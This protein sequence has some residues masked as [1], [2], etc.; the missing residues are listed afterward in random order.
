VLRGGASRVK[1]ATKTLRS[2]GRSGALSL[3]S[4][5]RSPRSCDSAFVRT[6]AVQV[7]RDEFGRFSHSASSISP[8]PVM[9]CSLGVQRLPP[10]P[11][12][13]PYAGIWQIRHGQ[14][15]ASRSRISRSSAARSTA[16]ARASS[17][18]SRANWCHRSRSRWRSTNRCRSSDS[19]PA[20][21]AAS[22]PLS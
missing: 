1:A 6:R 12:T 18:V 15:R 16:N 4:I 2:R 19:S 7:V 17:R 5:D 14:V 20:R 9:C 8:T 10:A 3:E 11:S 21:R 22:R 13:Q